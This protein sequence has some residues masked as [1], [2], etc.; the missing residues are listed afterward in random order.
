MIR[1]RYTT[2]ASLILAIIFLPYYVYVPLLV[3]A[4][5][6]FPFFWEGV[7]A[8]FLIDALYGPEM[9]YFFSVFSTLAFLSLV[10]AIIALPIRHRI[11][12]YA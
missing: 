4:I 1:R 9:H 5:I 6:I 11:R 8:G 12:A 3:V 7:L 2:L 10:L